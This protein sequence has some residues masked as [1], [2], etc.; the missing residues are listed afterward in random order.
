MRLRDALEAGELEAVDAELDRLAR[1]AAESRRTY[2]RWCLLVLQAA[3]AIFAGRLADG[4][5]LAEEAVALNR[6][7]G[8]DAD[9]EHTVQRLALALQRRRPHDAPL[10]AL[11]DYAARY[12]RLPVWAAM[13]AQAEH[14]LRSER[15]AARASRRCARDGFA[16]VLRTPDWL[17][18]LALLAEPVA[19]DGAPEEIAA[20]AEALAPH[21]GAQRGDGRRL[22]GV[23]PGRPPAGRAGRRG[24][25]AGRGRRAASRRRRGSRRA[26]ARRPGSSRRSPTGSA[27]RRRVATRAALRGRALALARDL[28]LPWVAAE[29]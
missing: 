7:H 17:C 29:L 10:A 1:L 11:R 5:R 15:R 24:G 3:R 6:R 16:A 19:A 8:D 26:G 28:E 20:L 2:Y 13:L 18:A 25:A 22:G 27:R 9:Q 21:A 12:P 23:R 14:G 4:E